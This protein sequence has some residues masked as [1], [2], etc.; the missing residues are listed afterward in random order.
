MNVQILQGA[1]EAARGKARGIMAASE[2]EGRELNAK[3]RGEVEAALAEARSLQAKIDRHSVDDEMRA[4]INSFAGGGVSRPG[5]SGVVRGA[6]LGAQFVASETFQWLQENRGKLPREWHS[7][8]SELAIPGIGATTLDES[9]GSGGKLVV[10]DYRP[11]VTS[12]PQRR[13]W[14]EQLFAPGSTT[15]NTVTT[16]RETTYTNTAAPTAE[17]AA[18]PES[19]LVF[20]AVSDGVAKPST[21]IPVTDEMLEDVPA[22]QGYINARLSLGVNLATDDQLLNGDGISPNMTGVLNRAGL[23]AAVA[24]GTDTNAD[25]IA[26]QIAAIE[27]DTEVMCDGVVIHPTNWMTIMLAKDGNGTY[28]GAGPLGTPRIATL[29]GLPVAVSSKIAVN[30]ALV[31]AFGT[32]GQVFNRSG[33]RV[34]ASNSHSDWFIKGLVAIRAERRLALAVYRAAAF[35]KVTGLN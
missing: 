32:Y 9:A 5:D 10:S 11:G 33:I 23:A 15:S 14:M 2:R 7:P 3:E 26:K 1:F 6:G 20:D 16:M 22:L 21:Y 19:T 12:I 4:L 24:R 25:A 30:T 17:G 31:G 27:S 18:R 13:I 28:Y 8:S 34:S 29:W 35:G